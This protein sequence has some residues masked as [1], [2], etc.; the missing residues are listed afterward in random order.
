MNK[1][2]NILDMSSIMMVYALN[3]KMTRTNALYKKSVRKIKLVWIVFG[4]FN[5]QL[6]N[7]LDSS[8]HQHPLKKKLVGEL[9]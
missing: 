2:K 1:L 7:L 4:L 5:V 9:N 8:H 6:G 3:L